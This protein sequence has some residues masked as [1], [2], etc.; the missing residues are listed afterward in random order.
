MSINI[1]LL[2]EICETAG[3]PGYEQRIREIVVER[4]SPL[5]MSCE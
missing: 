1:K 4:L 2:T 5:L 3:A